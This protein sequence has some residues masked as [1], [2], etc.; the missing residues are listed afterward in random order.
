MQVARGAVLVRDRGREEE[1]TV[2]PCA[3][4]FATTSDS[5]LT[6][7]SAAATSCLSFPTSIA[8]TMPS[9]NP[10]T[11]TGAVYVRLLRVR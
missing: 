8:P 11:I 7:D 9:R 1:D 3:A 10:A 6:S 4:T 2:V 5:A